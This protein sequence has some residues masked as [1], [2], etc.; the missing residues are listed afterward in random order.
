MLGGWPIYNVDL[1]RLLK[2]QTCSQI[3]TTG[4]IYR[5]KFTI[6]TII[7]Q[8]NKREIEKQKRKNKRKDY[9]VTHGATKRNKMHSW[10]ASKVTQ[11]IARKNAT[12][13]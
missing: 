10:I 1:D 5:L 6:T 12:I 8:C 11:C 9:E 13:L 7:K 2:K 3:F 4:K